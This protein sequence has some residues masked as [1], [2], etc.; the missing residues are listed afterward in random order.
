MANTNE[1]RMEWGFPKK[2]VKLSKAEI[3]SIPKQCIL[4]MPV[5]RIQKTTFHVD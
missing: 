5:C 3:Y 1:P 4:N 2:K